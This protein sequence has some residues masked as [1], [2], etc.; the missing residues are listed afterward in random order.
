V[1]AAVASLG[2][3]A[4]P[5]IGLGL[6]VLLLGE[7]LDMILLISSLLILAGIAIGIGRPR[8]DRTK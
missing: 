7:P 6:S 8:A 2:V 4:T 1:P 5:V 3:L